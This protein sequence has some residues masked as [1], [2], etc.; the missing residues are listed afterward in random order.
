MKPH[1]NSFRV[2]VKI[3]EI[4]RILSL[5]SKISCL[6]LL[7]FS[8]M[9]FGQHQ[10]ADTCKYVTYL[11]KPATNHIYTNSINSLNT[12]ANESA[13]DTIGI[14]YGETLLWEFG[15]DAAPQTAKGKGPFRIIYA[16]GGIKKVKMI[17]YNPIFKDSTVKINYINVSLNTL[18]A[19]FRFRIK[20]PQP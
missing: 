12:P 7:L 17:K 1:N 20:E 8:K 4:L 3:W 10:N 6:I 18:N 16:T 9:T 14:G 11:I 13:M 5:H 19:T 2:L 15:E